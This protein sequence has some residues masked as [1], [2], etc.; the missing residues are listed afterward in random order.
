M[1]LNLFYTIVQKSQ[2]WPKTQIKGGSCLKQPKRARIEWAC[3]KIHSNSKCFETS[4]HHV[5]ARRRTRWLVRDERGTLNGSTSWGNAGNPE[6][7]RCVVR[8]AGSI[9][10]NP[11]QT[12]TTKTNHHTSQQQS[13]DDLR[14]TQAVPTKTSPLCN[15]NF[16]Y[17]TVNAPIL[18]SQLH[19]CF[20]PGAHVTYR[21]YFL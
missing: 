19:T 2:K 18:S 1:P 9:L 8:M 3:Y 21:R 15:S 10:R 16:T 5:F 20:S 14:L 6:C 13:L 12:R 7:W 4:V 17:V 11:L